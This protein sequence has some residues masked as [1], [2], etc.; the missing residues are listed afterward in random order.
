M[1][2]YQRYY[3]GLLEGRAKRLNELIEEA[4][5]ADVV[6][7]EVLLLVQAAVQLKPSYFKSWMGNTWPCS[8]QE[9]TEREV[10]EWVKCATG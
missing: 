9:D 2:N 7:Q 1:S 3:M 10:K 4:A 6:C 5:P 8:A